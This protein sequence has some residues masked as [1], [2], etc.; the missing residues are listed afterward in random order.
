MWGCGDASVT[1]G[2]VW[3]L[4]SFQ[5]CCTLKEKL[6]IY[7][8][9]KFLFKALVLPLNPE[10]TE[11][12]TVLSKVV[13][14]AR[15]SHRDICRAGSSTHRFTPPM[16]L[17]ARAV[18]VQS[19]SQEPHLGVPCGC[20]DLRTWPSCVASPVLQRGAGLEAEQHRPKPMPILNACLAGS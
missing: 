2:M 14:F 20:R 9:S 10:L 7:I 16:D 12:T 19:L 6:S 18:P 13:S 17:M 4:C 8:F 5:S 1:A 15:K 3:R 11:Q